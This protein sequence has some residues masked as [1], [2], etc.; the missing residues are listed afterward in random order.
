MTRRRGSER[1]RGVVGD[2]F[3]MDVTRP[4]F[5]GSGHADNNV[6]CLP[7]VAKTTV[8]SVTQSTGAVHENLI[9]TGVLTITAAG[10][11]FR[12]CRF[13][14]SHSAASDGGQVMAQTAV[15]NGIATTYERC[16]FEPTTPGNR[17]NNYHGHDAKFLRCAMLKGV[18]GI[19]VYNSTARPV[20]VE[21]AGCWIGWLAWFN[22][23]GVHTTGIV[24]TH[25]DIFQAH[26]GHYVNVHGCFLQGAKFNAVNPGNVVLDANWEE[27]TI[28]AGN[29]SDLLAL[30]SGS[31][32]NR[33]PQVS[34]VFLAQHTASYTTRHL[35]LDKNWVW[36]FDHGIKLAS[37]AQAGVIDETGATVAT[38]GFRELLNV[39]VT[40][41]IFGGTP[42]NY[43][44]THKY[45]PLRY[46]S[47]VTVNGVRQTAGG[48][49]TDT[50]GNVWDAS[51]TVDATYGDS[52]TIAGNPIRHRV[53]LVT[54]A[55]T[56][57]LG[58][59]LA[60]LGT[61]SLGG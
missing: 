61:S 12:N 3:V 11:T 28:A 19:G 25:N 31:T 5:K 32:S 55:P 48:T 17:F 4:V 45:Y 34:Q 13:T 50:A 16:E 26:S 7:G 29:G 56:Q 44:A 24:G 49:F 60:P 38:T 2:G 20:N 21:A 27:F 46:D 47:N 39:T 22:A 53:D 57:N 9:I 18:D 35:T 43:G 41:N 30:N 36:N 51:A 54:A 23:D 33:W 58:L 15:T 59:G 42:R 1:R 37:N 8:A 14:Y 6:G 52:G 40:N 10:Q